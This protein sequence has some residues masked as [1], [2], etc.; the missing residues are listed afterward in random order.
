MVKSVTLSEPSTVRLLVHSD[1]ERSVCY[2]VLAH[3]VA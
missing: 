2:L 3:F 1:Q